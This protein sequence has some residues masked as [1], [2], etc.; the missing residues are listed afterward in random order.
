[1]K[2]RNWTDILAQML[3]SASDYGIKK[4]KMMY[5]AYVPHE[6]MSEL[7][8][9]LVENGLLSFNQQTR[10]YQITSK[11]TSFLAMYNEMCECISD[12]TIPLSS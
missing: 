7:L 6:Q 4:T 11:G 2:Y 9:L 8:G 1:M 3:E 10:R 12:V 5:T